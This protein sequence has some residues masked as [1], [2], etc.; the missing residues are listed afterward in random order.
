MVKKLLLGLMLSS[1]VVQPARAFIDPLTASLGLAACGAV[2]RGHSASRL[3]SEEA[4]KAKLTAEVVRLEE[5]ARLEE[6]ALRA[7]RE[8]EARLRGKV[9]GLEIALGIDP[10]AEGS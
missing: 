9:E 8:E 7:G 1:V 3:P 2:A 4:E 6:E 10:E 5:K